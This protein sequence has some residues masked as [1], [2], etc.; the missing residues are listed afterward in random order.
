MHHEFRRA[1]PHGRAL[2]KAVTR[3]AIEEKEVFNRRMRP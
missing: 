3:E 2:L 1:A